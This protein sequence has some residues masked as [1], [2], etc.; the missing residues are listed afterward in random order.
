[1]TASLSRSRR[2]ALLLATLGV[3]GLGVVTL[4]IPFLGNES[5]GTPTNVQQIKAYVLTLLPVGVLLYGLLALTAHVQVPKLLLAGAFTGTIGLAID[6]SIIR[7]SFQQAQEA[8]LLPF[9]SFLFLAN[10]SKIGAATFVGLALARRVTSPG[11]AI[12]VAV[13]ATAADVFSVFAGP[14]RALTESIERAE[15]SLLSDLLG[16]LLLLLPTFGNPMGFALGVSDLLFLAL[17]AATAQLLEGLRPRITLA[18]GCASILIA[19]LTGLLLSH[20]L[21]ALP[22]IALSFLLANLDS[23]ITFFLKDS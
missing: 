5:Y 10:A 17:F 21:P 18:L 13:L 19:M 1:M 7:P 4:T 12:L 2:F 15:P 23:L 14:T 11:V 22:F 16:L 9:L 6:Y 3:V 20:P 8:D